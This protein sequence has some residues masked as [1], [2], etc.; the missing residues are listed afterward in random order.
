MSDAVQQDSIDLCLSDI[1]DAFQSLC[2]PPVGLSGHNVIHL[3]PKYRQKLKRENPRTPRVRVWDHD[4]S[5][6]HRRCFECTGWQVFF[7]GCSDN[8]DEFTDTVTS[9]I[10]FCEETIIPTKTVSIFPNNKPWIS[11]ELKSILSGNR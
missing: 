3:V 9:Y 2:G 1:P 11:K 7:D 5:E 8:P 4:S 6:A 10:Q